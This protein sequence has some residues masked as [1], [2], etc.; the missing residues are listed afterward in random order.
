MTIRLVGAGFI[1][2]VLLWVFVKFWKITLTV[3]ATV[4]LGY[5]M[6]STGSILVLFDKM[7][8]YNHQLEL[9]SPGINFN[10][11]IGGFLKTPWA[12]PIWLLLFFANWKIW[13]GYALTKI[14]IEQNDQEMAAEAFRESHKGLMALGVGFY[15]LPTLITWA[16]GIV[17]AQ[18]LLTRPEWMFDNLLFWFCVALDAFGIG[19]CWLNK[20]MNFL[21]RILLFIGSCF[22][23][24]IVCL[25]LVGV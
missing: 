21:L 16:L 8:A 23:L 11:A 13:G 20:K 19:A 5:W 18:W 22:N 6:I 7:V 24:G 14:A 15:L 2:V 17:Y 9:V 3:G 10:D 4:L 12:I 25:I 1:A